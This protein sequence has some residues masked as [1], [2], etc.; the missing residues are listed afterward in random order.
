MRRN[1][2]LAA[3]DRSVGGLVVLQTQTRQEPR[4]TAQRAAGQDQP[5]STVIQST[6]IQ[7]TR[8]P[9]GLAWLQVS[10]AGRGTWSL[11]VMA[12]AV[13]AMLVG[14]SPSSLAQIPTGETFAEQRAE[15]VRLF[16]E[17][18]GIKNPRVLDVFR[19]THRHE[20]VP[21]EMRQ[22]AYRDAGL[23][24]GDGQTI[25]SPFIVAYMTEVLDPQP[26]DR[27]LEIGTGSGFQAAILSPLVKEVYS[28]EI[29]EPLGV[30]AAQT[31]ERLG[32]KN[33]FTKVGDGYLGWAEHAPFDKII[34]TCSPENVPQPLVDQL[35]EGGMI[36]VPVGERHQQTLYLMH[37]KDGKLE[38]KP[39]QPTLFVP[40]TGAAE[41]KREVLPDP[42]NPTLLNPDFE[43]GEDDQGHI[44]GWY[45]QRLATLV[46]EP[47]APSGETYVRFENDLNNQAS[48]LMQGLAL[49]GRQVKQVRLSGHYRGTR[50][51]AGPDSNQLAQIA[52]TF[53]DEN[54]AE[55]GFGFIGPF[56]GTK[57]WNRYTKLIRVPPTAREA[58]VR[59]GMFGGTGVADFDDVRVE[60]Y[61]R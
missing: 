49:D 56:R 47:D 57:T 34:V 3:S 55:V 22:F 54:R 31:L 5:P 27:V 21:A 1:I 48:H 14:M 58:I 23:P 51:I 15:M 46:K 30:R 61:G 36:V 2:Q 53:Y 25:S 7:P 8:L 33:V 38:G 26:T 44:R 42:G 6:V 17:G 60:R 24:I 10:H 20:F 59:I 9:P 39:L 45:Y 16:L 40:M 13:G 41:E 37:K 29:V 32:Y 52:I 43:E 4:A 18:A 28:I 11:I 35:K 12:I 19:Q 50:V